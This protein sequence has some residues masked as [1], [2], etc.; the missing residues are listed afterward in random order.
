[1]DQN[2]E[3]ESECFTNSKTELFKSIQIGDVPLLKEHLRTM[4]DLDL[5]LSS[6]DDFGFSAL[7]LAI[8]LQN[9]EIVNLLMEKG[10]DLGDSMLVAVDVGFRPA[11]KARC[12]TFSFDYLSKFNET[13]T[14]F[15]M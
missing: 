13:Q 8:K 3:P 5:I 7:S 10:P 6:E 2:E 9:E 15:V 4:E 1:M 14:V 12:F 11:I